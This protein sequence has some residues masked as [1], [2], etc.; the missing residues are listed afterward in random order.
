MIVK[1]ILWLP[2]PALAGIILPGFNLD[3]ELLSEFAIMEFVVGSN[4]RWRLSIH[5][6]RLD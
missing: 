3:W 1:N 4:Y 6:F 5:N 2:N